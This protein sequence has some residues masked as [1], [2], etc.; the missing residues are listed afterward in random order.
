VEVATSLKKNDSMGMLNDKQVVVRTGRLSQCEIVTVNDSAPEKVPTT[1]GS[2]P[3]PFL[4]VATERQACARP[5]IC[6]SLA[7]SLDL[8][9]PLPESI[10]QSRL[11]NHFQGLLP[12][13]HSIPAQQ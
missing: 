11:R 7:T 9:F 1:R 5:L 13:I 10:E 12:V 3:R 8:A 6:A 2:R 4:A